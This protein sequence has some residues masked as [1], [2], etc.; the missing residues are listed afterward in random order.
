MIEYDTPDPQ[1]SAWPHG[2][3]D[4]GGEAVATTI[5]DIE[6]ACMD[7]RVEDAERILEKTPKGETETA[8]YQ[9]HLGRVRESQ[10]RYEDAV[11]AFERALQLDATHRLTLFR[12]AYLYD[13][14]G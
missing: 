14:R 8:G 4:S 7:G 1:G 10:G 6:K 9:Y 5:S 11:E 2:N 12:L 13:L 3:P